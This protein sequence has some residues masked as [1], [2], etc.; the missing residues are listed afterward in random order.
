MI[1]YTVERRSDT[2]VNNVTLGVWLFLASEVMLFGGLFSAVALLRAVAT[3]WPDP[4]ADLSVGV[5]AVHTVVLLSATACA[6]RARARRRPATWLIAGTALAAIFLAAKAGEYMTE[7]S[8]GLRPADSTFL[9]TY[10]TLTGCHA[11]HV[12]GGLL[13][14]LWVAAGLRRV[15]ATLSTGRLWA[16]SMYWTFVDVVWVLVFATFYFGV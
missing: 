14:N 10:F 15:P 13:A 8:G 7:L 9:A 1:P 4:R 12:A 6:W 11:V 3:A 5:G 16:L 2:G